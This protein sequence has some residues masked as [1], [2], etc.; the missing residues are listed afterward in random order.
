MQQTQPYEFN[1]EQNRVISSLGAR[2][3]AV[4]GVQLLLGLVLLA[5]AAMLL[6]AWQNGHPV[7]PSGIAGWWPGAT[8]G[9]FALLPILV[10]GRV[11][12]AGGSFTRITQSQSRD[13]WH[14][15]NAL[16]ALDS[17]FGLARSLILFVVG[18]AFVFTVW[19]AAAAFG[20][21]K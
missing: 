8:V 17:A 18:I 19:I 11:R 16:G 21:F 13:M 14:L 9:V 12:S 20:L 2:M 15:M 1:D 6:L 3:V 10:G 5:L 7:A 4:G